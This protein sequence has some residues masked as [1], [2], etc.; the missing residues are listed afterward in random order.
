MAD[1]LG[2]VEKLNSVKH[3]EIGLTIDNK[4]RNLDGLAEILPKL[5]LFYFA[6]SALDDYDDHDVI[7]I[8]PASEL[9]I[10]IANAS[11]NVYKKLI[12]QLKFVP[13][14]KK[15][16]VLTISLDKNI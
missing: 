8:L 3:R 5:N 12:N 4:F 6:N 14:L 11:K 9:E 16:K 10:N 15:V 7:P 2:F 13:N 1:T